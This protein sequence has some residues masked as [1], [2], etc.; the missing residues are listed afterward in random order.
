MPAFTIRY[1]A[2]LEPKFEELKVLFKQSTKNKVIIELIKQYPLLS[3]RYTDLSERHDALLA[4]HWELL[5]LMQQKE[6]LSQKIDNLMTEA[7]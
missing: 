5:T 7:S 2:Q 3:Q 4:K 6:E 1:D